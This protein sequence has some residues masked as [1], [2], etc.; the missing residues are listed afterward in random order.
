MAAMIRN[1]KF[2]R[3]TLAASFGVVMVVASGAA[4]F[5]A[6]DQDENLLPD[7]KF[8]RNLMRAIGLRNGQEAGVDAHER[9][10]LVLPPN[11]DLP[12]P[13]A[14][15]SLTENN[16]AWPSDPDV[17]RRKAEQKAQA[18]AKPYDWLAS[19]NPLTPKELAAGKTD[20][21]AVKSGD[22]P[23]KSPELTPSQLGYVGGLFKSL[24]TIDNPLSGGKKTETAT[25]VREP[26]RASLTDP[27]AG[28]RTPSPTQPYGVNT[29]DSLPKAGP[30]DRQTGDFGK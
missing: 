5:A 28:Y 6:D 8:F 26:S 15:G 14:P 20:K 29:R 21:P 16:P 10:P 27:P 11:R 9:A 12:P 2:V 23:D 19:G 18:E 13:A 30:S 1:R 7:V 22:G 24:T 17:R 4:V 25:F 3:M